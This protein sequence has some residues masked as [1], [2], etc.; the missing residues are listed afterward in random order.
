MV[1]SIGYNPDRLPR[2]YSFDDIKIGMVVTDLC[3][4]DFGAADHKPRLVSLHPGITSINV[5]DATGFDLVVE[6][7]LPTTTAPT[8]AQLAVIAELD[9][10]GLR[11]KMIKD[12]PKGNRSL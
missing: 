2:G 8:M 3:V 10:H 12:D 6:G 11:S 7:Q 4:M 9:P 5:M 1:S